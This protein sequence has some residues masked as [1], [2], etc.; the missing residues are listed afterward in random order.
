MN[1][2]EISLK[3]A[4]LARHRVGLRS[5]IG[6]LREEK[7]MTQR[8]L[9]ELVGVTETTIANWEKGRRALEWFDRLIRLCRAL[10]C[11]PEDLVEYFPNAP[12]KEDEATQGGMSFSE[13]IA[14]LGTD[15]SDQSFSNNESERQHETRQLNEQ[16][17]TL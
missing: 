5:K 1:Q 11:K 16:A 17:S 14:M 10:Q 4:P 15:Q 3:S 12:A 8:D 13:M 7:N 6:V 2:K 9:S